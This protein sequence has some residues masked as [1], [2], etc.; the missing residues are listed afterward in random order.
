MK[1]QALY[2]FP[3]M[4]C[5][6]EYRWSQGM[7]ISDEAGRLFEEGEKYR[8]GNGVPKDLEKAIEYYEKAAGM[9]NVVAGLYAASLK[10][11][12]HEK[13]DYNNPPQGEYRFENT[14]YNNP[15]QGEYQFADPDPAPVQPQTDSY[16][17]PQGG[18]YRFKKSLLKSRA[19]WLGMAAFAVAAVLGIGLFVYQKSRGSGVQGVGE[20]AS[21]AVSAGKS[22]GED[23]QAISQW[24]GSQT[25]W[26]ESGSQAIDIR[27][28]SGGESV[29]SAF[30]PTPTPTPRPTPTPT[31]RPTPTPVPVAA[32]RT[33]YQ[34]RTMYCHASEYVTLRSY[35]STS[36]SPLGYIVHGGAVEYLGTSDIFYKVNYEGTTG[37]VMASYFKDTPPEDAGQASR[38]EFII[39]NCTWQEAFQACVNKGGHLVTFD[40]ANEYRCIIAILEDNDNYRGKVFYVGG[41][42]DPGDRSYYW[43]DEKNTFYG[44]ALNSYSS[45]TN[46][47]WFSGE[48]SFSD[49]GADETVLGILRYNGKWGFNDEPNNIFSVTSIYSGLIGYICEY[50][51]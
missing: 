42:R 7:G 4:F 36:A 14:N 49:S 48:P 19:F 20:L 16:N 38:Y 8:E 23:T 45:W 6:R 34:G 29:S 13:V 35:A 41:R 27:S 2:S 31:P 50:D 25:A 24:S 37:Y 26:Q 22:Y 18:E 3:I 51:K 30:R 9:G 40:S 46:T 1:A 12:R 44:S 17:N 11:N 15:P 33:T 47:Y 32:S 21:S 5:I 43:V 28:Y 39:S 10:K